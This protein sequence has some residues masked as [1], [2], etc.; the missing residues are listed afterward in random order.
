MSIDT[1]WFQNRIRDGEMSQARLAN[2]LG[3]DRSALSLMLHGKRGMKLEEATRIAEILALPIDQV[4]AHAGVKVPRGPASVP[5]VGTVDA[6][7]VIQPRKGARV[8]SHDA[9]P[10]ECVAV[11]CEDRA[12]TMYNWTFYYV[13]MSSVTSEAIERLSVCQLANDTRHLM[14]PSRGFEVSTHNLR[15]VTGAILENQKLVVASPVLWIR[16]G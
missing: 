14:I 2:L 5:L 8:E 10:R 4:L 7:C 9:L 6:S 15:A 11:R 3:I 16:T 1:K 12:S 13:P